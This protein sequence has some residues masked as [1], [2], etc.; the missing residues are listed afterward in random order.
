M[1]NIYKFNC[2]VNI[3]L[4]SEGSNVLF[5]VLFWNRIYKIN[6]KIV[7]NSN[8]IQWELLELLLQGLSKY[9]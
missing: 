6:T 9:K 4:I 5:H 3:K 7:N 8:I 1:Q 2:Y